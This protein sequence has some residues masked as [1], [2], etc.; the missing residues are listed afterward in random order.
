MERPFDAIAAH[1]LQRYFKLT[2]IQWR[3]RRKHSQILSII[4]PYVMYA[5]YML[6][7]HPATKI[8]HLV[9]R[10]HLIWANTVVRW[11]QAIIDRRSSLRGLLQDHSSTSLNWICSRKCLQLWKLR[12]LIS[13]VELPAHPK[14]H[15][16]TIQMACQ[17]VLHE[18]RLSCYLICDWVP[19]QFHGGHD[20]FLLKNAKKRISWS[21]SGALVLENSS[22]FMIEYP[23]PAWRVDSEIHY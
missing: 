3:L 17:W 16:S 1:P 13:V 22:R 8:H 18:I 5:K 14:Y 10:A 6:W 7:P 4:W 12:N 11:S 9:L 15:W 19:E 23:G 21:C 2:R 20:W